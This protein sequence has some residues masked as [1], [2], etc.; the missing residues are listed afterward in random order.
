MPL[1][2]GLV[3]LPNVG[4]STLFNALTQAGAAV[5]NYP[6]TTIDPNVG[7]VAVADARLERIAEIIQPERVV[8]ATLRVVDIAGLV[9]GASHGEGLGN[10]F[11]SH[12]RG[13]DA[14]AMVVRCFTDDNIPHVTSC[15][16]PVEDIETVELELI[17][18]DLAILER[19]AER[20]QAQAKSHPR[21]F[22]EKLAALESLLEALRGGSALRLLE[23]Q[24]TQLECLREVDLLTTKPRLYV[25]NVGEDQLP[26]GGE[27]VE[28][29]RWKAALEGAEV[30]AL[31]ALLESELGAWE[32]A[33]AAAY[34][35]EV[36]LD[37]PGLDRFIRAGYHLLDYVTF[38]TTT[39][40]HEVRA[41]TLR[42]GQTALE[43]AG[44]IHSDMERGFI[45]AEVVGYQD[46]N[47][48][49]SVARARETGRLR[50]EGRD[51]VVQDGDVVHI[52]FNV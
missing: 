49:G 45:R 1:Q 8:P 39:G 17:L 42:R 2:L 36:G 25:A 11:L 41:W 22:Q 28:R 38:F 5:A 9:K 51:Y 20:L 26:T 27:L 35:S 13:V 44:A 10:Q 52:R 37:T 33:D 46:L 12:I 16:N 4:K 48:A 50:L 34:L 23:L 14:V 32:P 18:S 47:A 21:E 29:V 15:L 40:G 19:Y 7:V 30:I 6:F 31:C 24:P 43:A 3:G